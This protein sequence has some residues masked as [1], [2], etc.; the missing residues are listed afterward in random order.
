MKRSRSVE[1]TI[2]AAA[3]ASLTACGP[4][5]VPMTQDNVPRFSDRSECALK[6]GEANCVQNADGSGARGYWHPY[7]VPGQT[8]YYPNRGG[9]YG[10]SPTSSY[11]PRS[12]SYSSGRSSYRPATTSTTVRSGFGTTGSAAS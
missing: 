2:L 6:Y 11:T 8:Y 1:L 12:S 9:Y 5:P 4:D 3:A 7:F 10:G